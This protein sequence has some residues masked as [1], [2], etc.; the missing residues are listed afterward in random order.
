MIAPEDSRK[1]SDFALSKKDELRQLMS[2]PSY[3]GLAPCAAFAAQLIE[4]A[5]GKRIFQIEAVFQQNG[6]AYTPVYYLNYQ[7]FL[8]LPPGCLLGVYNPNGGNIQ[9]RHFV[10]RLKQNWVVGANHGGIFLNR[11]RNYYF[12]YCTEQDFIIANNLNQFL[13]DGTGTNI[14]GAPPSYLICIDYRLN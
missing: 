10:V 11:Q 7:C 5:T 8:S 6:L 4:K 3:G 14:P 13:Y 2:S 1:I 9:M 12:P